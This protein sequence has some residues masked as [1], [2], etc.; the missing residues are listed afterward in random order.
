MFIISTIEGG[1]RV[2]SE[3]SHSKNSNFKLEIQLIAKDRKN[4]NAKLRKQKFRRKILKMLKRY[5]GV[6]LFIV[7]CHSVLNITAKLWNPVV[8]W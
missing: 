6:S 3:L 8:M 4:V 2:F 1:R 7:I 5:S